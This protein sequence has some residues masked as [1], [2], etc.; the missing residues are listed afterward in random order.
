MR[1]LSFDFYNTLCHFTPPREERQAQAAAAHGVAVSAERLREAYV[2]AEHFWTLENARW[3]IALR[4][5]DERTA[6]YATYEQHLFAAAGVLVPPDLALRIYRTYSELPRQLAL[7]DDAL[8]ALQRARALGLG[9]AI[10][11]NTDRNL[12]A[13]CETLGLAAHID[14]LICSCDV[15]C[16]KPAPEIF[17]AALAQLGVTPAEALHVGDQYHSDIVGARRVGMRAVLLDRLGLL[18]GFIDCVRVRDL[19]AVLALPDAADGRLQ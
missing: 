2:E 19:L 14:A 3:P 12:A 1:A 16:E 13:E 11:S 8:P 10:V 9:V 17:H 4:E 18:D 15:G 6:F 5:G 7:F